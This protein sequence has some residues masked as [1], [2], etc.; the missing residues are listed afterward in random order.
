[1]KIKIIISFCLFV[2]VA[3]LLMSATQDDGFGPYAPTP[4]KWIIPKGWPQ[5][6]IDI[7]AKNKLTEEGF[8]L[9]KKLFYDT[10]LSKDNTVSCAGCHQP[11]AAFATF[12]HDLSHGIGNAFK[13]V[14]NS[15]ISFAENTINKFIRAINSAIGLINNIPGV[16]IGKLKELNIPK[17]KVGM[18]NVPY[19][20]YLALLH[21]GERVLTKEAINVV[22][23]VPA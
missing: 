16:N 7:F 23:P 8:Q 9:G 11:F 3:G 18:A 1:M 14:V 2:V 20:D 22:F 10:R 19:D 12:D 21:K 4:I 17:L 6:P 13:T 15:I 5:P